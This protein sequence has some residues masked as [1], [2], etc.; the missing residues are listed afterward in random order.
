[1][2]NLKLS[3]YGG[4]GV[5]TGANF[6][7]ESISPNLRVDRNK[8]KILID[9]GLFQGSRITERKNRDSFPYD[10]S[11]ID[12]LFITHA[13]LDHIGRIPKLTRD[14]FRGRIYSTDAT[15][16]L[17][18]LVMRDSIGIMEKEAKWNNEDVFYSEEDIDKAIELWGTVPYNKTIDIKDFKIKFKDSGHILGSAM[19]EIIYKG[20]K[21]VF[22]GDLGNS[23]APLLK[24]AQIINNADYLIIESVYGDRAHEPFPERA[25]KLKR[26]IKETIEIGGV[27]MIPVFSIERTQILLYELNNLIEKGVIPKIPVFL[28]SPMA[29]KATMI[30]K[31]YENLFNNNVQ[32][33]IK[34]GDDI[35]N[36]PCLSFS[37]E[38]SES[39]AIND[40][41]NPKII[42]AGSGM[43]NGGRIVHHEKRYLS[44]P[45]STLLIIGYQAINTLGR[46]IQDGATNV[47]M[48]G[49]NVPI[50]AKIE[51][52]RGYSAHADSDGLVAFVKNTKEKVKKVFI[53]MGEPKSANT[54]ANRLHKELNVDAVVPNEGEQTEL[55]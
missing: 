8:T 37:L 39:K 16:D 40:V 15:K 9:C 34:S 1:M 23:P 20:K 10:P 44:D 26:I 27:L 22:T 14:G 2:D 51:N 19:I 7:L 55:F 50:R 47:K 6:L 49:E 48:F 35:F 31:K 4:T 28:D 41:E 12:A 5:V 18:E 17:A 33:I 11:S 21:I 13:H 38:T 42:M 52:I 30:Y 43:S 54:L 46:K 24:D 29:I 32:N 3:F 45:K 25:E 36:F 53:T